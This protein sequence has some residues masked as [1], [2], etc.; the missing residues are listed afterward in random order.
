MKN[1]DRLNL[2]IFV[3]FALSII[4]FIGA[5]I[6]NDSGSVTLDIVFWSLGW[7]LGLL[8]LVLLILALGRLVSGLA[9]KK[10]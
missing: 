8:F 3:V 2:T 9:N 1:N 4:A 5:R 6:A 7:L 10:R